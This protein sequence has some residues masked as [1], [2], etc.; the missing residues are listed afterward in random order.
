MM[1]MLNTSLSLQI[2]ALVAAAFLFSWGLHKKGEGTSV[3]KFFG[4]ITTVIALFSLVC[5]LYFAAKIW[6]EGRMMRE[7]MHP[8]PP[9]EMQNLGA[10][11]TPS[12]VDKVPPIKKK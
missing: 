1:F 6:Q 11:T 5:S 10:P 3:A 2:I 12:M 9:H 7:G 8:L 4:F